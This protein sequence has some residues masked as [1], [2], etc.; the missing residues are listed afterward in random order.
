MPAPNRLLALLYVTLLGLTAMV[1]SVGY[2]AAPAR[3]PQLA[4]VLLGEPGAHSK[5]SGARFECRWDHGQSVNRCEALVEDELLVVTLSSSGCIGALGRRA[6]ACR[7]N[8]GALPGYPSV[9]LA[10]ATP[11][12]RG[13]S[14]AALID[15]LGT[16]SECGWGDVARLTLLLFL[17]GVLTAIWRHVRSFKMRLTYAACALVS[18]PVLFVL[19]LLWNVH[20]GY[21]D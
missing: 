17:A 1:W 15:F 6:L 12:V 13:L 8:Y 18:M 16:L 3:H 20:L 11:P 7:I 5:L 10:L 4:M 2:F 21:A 9:Q 19:M 14:M